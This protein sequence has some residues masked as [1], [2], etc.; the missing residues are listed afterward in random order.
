D[1]RSNVTTDQHLN[2][3]NRAAFAI[4]AVT[5][6]FGTLG[7][8]VV[9]GFPLRQT[10]LVLAKN[11]AMPFINDGARLQFRGE[12]YNLFNQTNFTAPDVNLASAN[13]GRVGS[14]LD[15]R[16]V[17]LALKLSF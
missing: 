14:T 5:S 7:R 16:F 17:Q 6:P 15:P 9:Y 10:N 12:F 11:F 13:F 2:Y 4:P 3:F 1:V 8:N